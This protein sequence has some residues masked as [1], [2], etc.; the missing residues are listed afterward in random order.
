MRPAI[1]SVAPHGT[2]RG[3]DPDAFDAALIR[4]LQADGRASIHELAQRLGASRDLVAQRLRGLTGAGGLRIV[5]ALDPGF[6]GHHLLVHARAEVDGP[7]GPI[8]REIAEF[9]DAVFVSMASGP[10]PLVF[11]TRHG[12]SRELLEV[13]DEVRRMPSVRRVL[14]S[15]Y[16]EVFKGFF[17]SHG[18]NDVALDRIDYELIAV[19]QQDGRTSYR[20]LADTVHLSPSSARARVHR[21][22]DSGVIRISAIQSGGISRNRLAIGVGITVSGDPDPIR[23]YIMES[24]DIDFATRA[25][26]SFDFIATMVGSSPAHLLTVMDAIRS[27]PGV[28]AL[29][30][31][32]H[33]DV[34]K[35]DYARTLG[36]VLV[37]G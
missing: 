1:R 27:L 21:L 24:P 11:E 3:H 15:T 31:W 14:V 7:V 16:V 28:S 32:T 18:R 33:Y 35:E 6:V 29:D 26:G 25:H 8:A 20:E 30:S 4:A 22:I 13:L 12:D 5:A 9:P 2:T 17:V 37:Q 19:L 23:R 10:F 34:V 36:R